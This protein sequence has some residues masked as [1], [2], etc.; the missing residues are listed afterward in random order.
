MYIKFT[1]LEN[2][3]PRFLFA[4]SLYI[5]DSWNQKKMRPRLVYRIIIGRNV[6]SYGSV[7]VF[8]STNILYRS[9][10]LDLGQLCCQGCYVLHI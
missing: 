2:D 1:K 9:L 10:D 5:S 4:I 3:V 6:S 8:V 7:I